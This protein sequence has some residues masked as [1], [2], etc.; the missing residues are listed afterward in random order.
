M[1]VK[2]WMLVYSDDNAKE[3][4]ASRPS[5]D[6]QRTEE[7]LHELYPSSRFEKIEDGDLFNTCP[8]NGNIYAGYY[9][10]VF[11]ISA[12]EFAI[13]NPSRLNR[14]FLK[15]DLGSTIHLLAMHSVVDWL[16]FGYWKNRE[17]ERSFSVSPDSGIIENIGERFP[18]ELPFWNGEYPAADP[19]DEYP[20]DFHPLELGEAALNNFF[21]YQ[22]EGVI[23]SANIDP[24]D[25]TL[26]GY[27]LVKPWWKFW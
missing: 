9:D 25:I 14:S 5:L 21:G 26:V 6:R 19:E 15:P 24:E 23:D 27:R 13:D 20:L 4:L 11:I 3:I 18:F 1:G 8:P 2:T 17:L 16:A 22:L 7:L 12:N 10:G